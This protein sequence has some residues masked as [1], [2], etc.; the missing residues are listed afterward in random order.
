MPNNL[1][2][3][4]NIYA[5]FG[6]G[7]VP[8]ILEHITDEC[9]WEYGLA[10]H[11]IPWLQR[12]T[13]RTGAGEFFQTLVSETEVKSFEVPSLLATDRLVVAL[14]NIEFLVKRTG[15]TVRETDEVHLWH[16]DDKGR[17]IKFRHCADTLQH[18]RALQ[19]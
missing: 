16:F 15:K 17:V 10:P 1:T 3:I 6:R 7:D 19:A 8:A 4:Q 12:R 2:T 14:V 5:A 11:D 13:G 9:V 18:A